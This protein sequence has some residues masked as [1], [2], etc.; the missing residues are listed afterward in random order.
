MMKETQLYAPVKAL[1]TGQGYDVKSEISDCDIV[2]IRGTEDPVIVELKTS[3]SLALLLQGVDRQGLSDWV[4]VAVPAGKG[5]RWY[6]QVKDATKLCRRL[7]LG[8]MSVHFRPGGDSVEV[9]VDPGPYAPRIVKKRRDALL[10]EFQARVGDHNAGGQT[11]RPVVTAYRQDALRLAAELASCGTDSPAKLARR[12]GVT[13]AATILQN[14][15]YGWFERVSRG[16]YTLAPRGVE[17]LDIYKDVVLSLTG[18][19]ARSA[20]PT[21]VG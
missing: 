17:A 13:R 14:D 16:I 5:R 12:L 21:D 7:G 19:T 18:T 4:Y 10:K 1:L 6:N 8:F 11:R 2:A 15:H 3:L 20:G 9:H